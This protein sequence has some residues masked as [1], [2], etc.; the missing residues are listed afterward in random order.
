MS[1]GFKS[2]VI[3]S[4]CASWHCQPQLS[5]Q[6]A[7][8]T[9]EADKGFGCGRVRFRVLQWVPDS[10]SLDGI[11]VNEHTNQRHYRRRR[12]NH[13]LQSSDTCNLET[14][15]KRLFPADPKRWRL[16][17]RHISVL[18]LPSWIYGRAPKLGIA[19]KEASQ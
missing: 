7:R 17:W 15:S 1:D 2:K 19:K 6:L 18:S 16:I 12:S 8:W 11:Y 10:A 9:N 3:E 14:E 5:I 4:S 13:S